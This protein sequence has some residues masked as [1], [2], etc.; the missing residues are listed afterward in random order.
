MYA[1]IR[2]SETISVRMESDSKRSEARVAQRFGSL[3]NDNLPGDPSK[4]LRFGAKSDKPFQGPATKNPRTGKYTRCR[5][6]GVAAKP[7]LPSGPALE[8][9][10]HKN[11]GLNL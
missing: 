9:I 10:A 6:H 2:E 3:C 11:D 8:W 1:P 5:M 4:S 7:A